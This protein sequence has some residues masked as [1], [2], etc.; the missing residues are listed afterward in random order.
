MIAA[1]ADT[2]AVIWY[3]YADKRLSKT[4]LLQFD[5]TIQSG[6]QIAVSSMSLSE[7]LYL[8]ERGRVNEEVFEGTLALLAR[9]GSGL[10]ELSV[11]SNVVRAMRQ[12]KR[13]EVPELPDRVIAATAL[14][15]GVPLITRDLQIQ[16][17]AVETVW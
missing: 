10:I 12:I 15:L 1:V 13:E 4:A 17:S 2:H 5:T 16:S 11:D 9:S 8:T 3:V 6:N 7:I 14:L